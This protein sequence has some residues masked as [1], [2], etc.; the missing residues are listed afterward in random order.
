MLTLML[1]FVE[2]TKK[3]FWLL[4]WFLLEVF[5]NGQHLTNSCLP[6]HNYIE[7]SKIGFRIL[8]SLGSIP[9]S[10]LYLSYMFRPYLRWTFKEDWQTLTEIQESSFARCL[11]ERSGRPVLLAGFAAVTL[12]A[13]FGRSNAALRPSAL[14]SWKR[15]ENHQSP[16]FAGCRGCQTCSFKS[17]S[18]IIYVGLC[19]LFTLRVEPWWIFS[20]WI[21]LNK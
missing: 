6:D 11:S 1:V 9:T 8:I 4:I 12:R 14:V 7:C 17:T 13:Y 20:W 18:P 21:Y 15:L 5:K 16:S 3:I 19:N 10:K 2:V